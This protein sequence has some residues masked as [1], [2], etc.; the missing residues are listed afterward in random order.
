MGHLCRYDP[1]RRAREAFANVSWRRRRLPGPKKSNS[2]LARSPMRSS[3]STRAA[4]AALSRASIK[5]LRSPPPDDD[6]DEDDW[7]AIEPDPTELDDWDESLSD[8][9]LDCGP[10]ED[11]DWSA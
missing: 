4:R 8:D 2:T 9:D 5:A 6:A 1:T 10:D 3:L 7:E 11:D